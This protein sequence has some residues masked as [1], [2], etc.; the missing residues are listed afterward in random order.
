MTNLTF[1]NL[2]H[3]GEDYPWH[4]KVLKEPV[5]KL[6]NLSKNLN[7]EARVS[8]RIVFQSFLT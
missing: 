3:F 4:T 7:R 6:E 5:E 8:L 2:D 1:L